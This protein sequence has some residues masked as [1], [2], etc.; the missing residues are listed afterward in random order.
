MR[1]K[2]VENILFIVAGAIVLLAVEL[3]LIHLNEILMIVLGFIGFA[4]LLNG[5]YGL[6]NTLSS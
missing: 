5:A 2:L 1:E 6:Y 4:A 3:K